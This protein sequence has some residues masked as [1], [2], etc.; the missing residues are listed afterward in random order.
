VR[1]PP[2]CIGPFCTRTCHPF[3]DWVVC[4]GTV[5]VRTSV[6]SLHTRCVWRLFCCSLRAC[7]SRELAGQVRSQVRELSDRYNALIPR[8]VLV[9]IYEG[10][11]IRG[12]YEYL[13]TSL[14]M[15]LVE[16][17]RFPILTTHDKSCKE[18]LS[19]AV[20]TCYRHEV[21]CRWVCF[22]CELSLWHST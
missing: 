6:S 12:N 22:A 20:R 18:R 5:V 10:A 14:C 2:Y 21:Q 13:A 15:A 1:N 17:P 3:V 16:R 4:T 19:R 11:P 8:S 9:C 7:A